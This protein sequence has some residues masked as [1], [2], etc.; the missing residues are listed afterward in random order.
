MGNRVSV[1]NTV[2]YPEGRKEEVLA[3]GRAVYNTRKAQSD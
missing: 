1:V 3:E 2:V